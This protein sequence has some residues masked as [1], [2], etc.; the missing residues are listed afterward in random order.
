MSNGMV[1]RWEGGTSAGRGTEAGA[2]AP[3]AEPAAGTSR[4]VAMDH[5]VVPQF[6]NWT[7]TEAAVPASIQGGTVWPTN[8]ATGPDGSHLASEMQSLPVHACGG[9]MSPSQPARAAKSPERS[10]RWL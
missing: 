9:S 6:A 4:V 1:T 10:S 2:Q 7:E 8:W 5:G 3:A